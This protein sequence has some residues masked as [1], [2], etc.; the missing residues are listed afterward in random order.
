MINTYRTKPCEIEAME[1]T[2]ESYNDIVIFTNNKAKGL[3]VEKCINGKAYCKIETLEGD[4]VAT[5]GDFIIKG[6]RGEFYPCK[7]DVFH[8]KYE[9]ISQ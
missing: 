7:P 6:L 1:F 3:I 5:E 9:V 8:K 2:R 4:M